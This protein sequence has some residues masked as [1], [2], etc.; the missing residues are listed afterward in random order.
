L[1][2]KGACIA[3]N[4]IGSARVEWLFAVTSDC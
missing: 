2:E 1:R 4:L 3:L